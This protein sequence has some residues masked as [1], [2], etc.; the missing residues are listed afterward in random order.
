MTAT[1]FYF[2]QMQFNKI[3][4]I[5]SLKGNDN[6]TYHFGMQH[7]GVPKIEH[8]N[9]SKISKT[10]QRKNPQNKFIDCQYLTLVNFVHFGKGIELHEQ[11][12]IWQT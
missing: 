10:Q 2:E 4:S 11:S 7:A 1:K 3:D 8:V 5:Q 6:K 12:L 9:G